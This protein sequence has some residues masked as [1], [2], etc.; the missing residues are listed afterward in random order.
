MQRLDASKEPERH[1]RTALVG[2]A[3]LALATAA[4]GG[5]GGGDSF[6]QA[7]EVFTKYGC[8]ASGCHDSAGSS[9]GFNMASSGWQN[10]LVGTSP[11]AG[12][13]TTLQSACAGETPPAVYL[14]D[15]S[16]PAAGL[17]ISKLDGSTPCGSRMPY[18]G[19]R[20]LTAVEV[21][22]V[23]TWATTLTAN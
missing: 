21:A 20:T 9:A 8:A 22:R 3:L 15:G 13:G 16:N 10:N 12:V 17:F 18:G 4:C 14:E 23:T 2:A 7:Q 1:V 5:S 19:V 6:T 11:R